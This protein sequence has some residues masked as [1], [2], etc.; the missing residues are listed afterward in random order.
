MMQIVD[1]IGWEA[2]LPHPASPP[3]EK[4]PGW[5]NR[6]EVRRRVSAELGEDVPQKIIDAKADRLCRRGLM[7]GCARCGCR[8][9]F[10]LTQ[11]GREVLRAKAD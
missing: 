10:Y 11:K 8:G 7:K 5:A 6:W 9:D 2:K 1:D 4:E 3:H